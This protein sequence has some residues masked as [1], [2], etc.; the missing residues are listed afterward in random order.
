MS[1]HKHGRDPSDLK[2][3]L[4][5]GQERKLIEAVRRL[6]SGEERV[7]VKDSEIVVIEERK[8][9]D[10]DMQPLTIQERKIIE[11]VRELDY[12]E[13]RVVVKDSEIVQIE[14]KKSIKL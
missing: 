11:I 14:E 5:T 1:H 6:G 13:E 2:E 7:V 9:A 12:G 8:P 4:L 10:E 3:M